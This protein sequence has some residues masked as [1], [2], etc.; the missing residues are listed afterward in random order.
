MCFAGTRVWAHLHVSLHTQSVRTLSVCLC[1]PRL[2]LCL[3]THTA[4]W[5]CHLGLQGIVGRGPA[6]RPLQRPEAA[7]R[8][9]TGLSPGALPCSWSRLCGGSLGS[10]K[11][12]SPGGWPC[13]VWSCGGSCRRSR[14]PTGASCRP[15]R[16]ASSGRHSW[17]SGCRPRLGHRPAPCTLLPPPPPTPAANPLSG[18]PQILQCKKKTSETEQQ[19]LERCAE[20]EQLRLR[21]GTRGAGLALPALPSLTPLLP[22][23]QDAG[24]SQD[25]E[26]AL[27]RLEEEQQR[28]A[29]G[30][31]TGASRLPLRHPPA[32][33]C[34]A[35]ERQPGPG[36]CAAPGAAGPG[37]L[38]QPGPAGRYPQGDQRLGTRPAGAGAAG[39]RLEA[40]GRGGQG[41]HGARGSGLTP[42]N[43][44]AGLAGEGPRAS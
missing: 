22:H 21:V 35:Q 36:E 34:P 26:S 6:W 15:I 23:P 41:G 39:G 42:G 14:P 9:G 20:L 10:Q 40:R 2:C 17:C 11:P 19:L 3:A 18:H 12:R 16:R 28:W 27:V 13:R 7:F 8:G 5:A 4:S 32:L 38:G 25:L 43:G 1:L 24:H 37:E 44:L 31:R 33:L 30:G 29:R